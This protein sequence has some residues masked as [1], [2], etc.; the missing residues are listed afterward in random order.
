MFDTNSRVFLKG[1]AFEMLEPCAVKV[2]CTVLR[3]PG[4]GNSPGLPGDHRQGKKVNNPLLRNIS[5]REDHNDRVE[6]KY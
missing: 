6:F 4:A 2:A 3:G 5:L 1:M